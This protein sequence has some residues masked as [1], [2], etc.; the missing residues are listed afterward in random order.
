MTLSKSP[1]TVV[2]TGA[3]AGVGRA[4]ARE[5]GKHGARVGLLARG[6][7]GLD[8]AAAEV[9]QAGGQ[10]LAIPT[11]IASFD[12]VDAAAEQV[13]S[14]FGGID[15]WVNVAFTSVFA[16]FHEIT[17]DEYRRATD[18]TYLG[19]V[20]GTMAALRRMRPRDRG[21]I[22]QVGS[23][24]SH[25]SIPLQS[26]YCGAKHAVNGF[27]ESLRTE[28]LHDNSNVQVTVVQMPA[29]NTPQFSWVLSRLPRQPQPVPPIYQ[30]EVAARA[31][32]YAAKHPR[33]KEYWVGASTTATLLGQRLFP[34][35][36][37]RYLA[38]NGYASQQTD[39]PNTQDA[40][41]WQPVDGEDGKDF[42]AH[43][44]FDSRSH[45]V[46]AQWWLRE[47]AKPLAVAA[48]AV[49]AGVAGVAARH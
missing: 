15:V 2:I 29:L 32:Y 14:R 22:V 4:A 44:D 18:V 35:L 12:E 34:A 40:N 16:P 49:L 11:D 33:H 48:G 23:A 31:V 19:F 27:T 5:F 26:V 25:R 13:E 37:D 7:T 9:E 42:G 20:W 30:P 10:A 17:P 38:R 47:N 41:L 36:L 1:S 24:L 8:A 21:A 6:Q 43:G 39:Q 45:A 46:S 3:S 28:L